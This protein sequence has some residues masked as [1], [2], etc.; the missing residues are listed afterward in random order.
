MLKNVKV[1]YDLSEETY[2]MCSYSYSIEHVA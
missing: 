1:Q 2:L